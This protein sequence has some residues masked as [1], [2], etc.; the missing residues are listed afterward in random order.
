LFAVALPAPAQ[1]DSAAA[2]AGRSVMSGVYSAAQAE[3]GQAAH[4]VSCLGC[5]GAENYTGETFEKAWLNRTVFDF[6]DRLRNTMP[7]DNPGSVK[8]EDYIDIIAY[9][10]SVN[11]YPPGDKELSYSEDSLRLVRIDVK[12]PGKTPPGME[13]PSPQLLRTIGQAFRSRELAAQ[14]M[15][16]G[17][18]GRAPARPA[19]PLSQP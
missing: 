11:G 8:H 6:F 2:S 12:P 14:R 16:P 19:R 10:L 7:D 17:I 15:G 1:T 18:A 4:K 13:A 3:R 9:I 5:H